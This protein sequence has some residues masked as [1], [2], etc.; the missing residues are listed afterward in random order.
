MHA[1]HLLVALSAV[2]MATAAV[3]RTCRHDRANPGRGW[4]YIVEGDD[5]NHIA[6]DFDTTAAFIGKLNGI[7]NL[8]FIPAWTTIIVP[9]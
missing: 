5:L 8:D 6:A 3:R 2:G 9:C 1:S 7:T 4:Y